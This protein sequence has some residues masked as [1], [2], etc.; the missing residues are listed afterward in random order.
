[1]SLRLKTGTTL[2]EN[3]AITTDKLAVGSIT[4]E[5]G[6]I[7]SLDLGTATVG[8]LDGIRIMGQS[9]RGEQLSG[10]AIDGMVITGGTYRTTGG[11][12]SWSDA[13]L[14]IAQHDGTSMV[15]FPT[16]GSPLSL[17]ASD[18][19]IERASIT[20]LDLSY[21]AVRSGGE[22]T[23][24]SGVTPP[25]SPPE[26]TT[27]WQKV[28][29]LPK[30]EERADVNG[31]A[32]GGDKWVRAVD[33]LGSEGDTL[34]RRETYNADGALGGSSHIDSNRRYG[35]AVIGDVV[36]SLGAAHVNNAPKEMFGYDLN[37]GARVTRWKLDSFGGVDSV[38]K[39]AI[40]A[41]DGELFVV[42]VSGGPGVY[43]FRYDTDG[44]RIEYSSTFWDLKYTRDVQGAHFDGADIYVSHHQATRVYTVSGGALTRKTDSANASGWA[45]WYNPNKSGAGMVF[46]GGVPYVV[47]SGAVY[48]GSVSASEYTR[49]MCFTWYDG[50]HET[51]ASPVATI[52]VGAR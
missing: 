29:S 28:A 9:I 36:Y 20:D 45:G 24:A 32:R 11:T 4:A 22:L 50:T 48:Q 41:H 33:V 17:T 18:T 15:R 10:D 51:T 8:E 1:P 34:D 43:M 38:N 46:V 6:I 52:D 2:I 44:N 37:T 3:G 30:P 21:G 39:L 27:G 13:G 7:E 12:G 5:S 49:E 23:L 26:L 25:P 35:V 14:F 31:L 42:G 47:D 16:D 40:T 19:Q